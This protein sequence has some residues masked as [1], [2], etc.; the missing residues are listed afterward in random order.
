MK[1]FQEADL[2]KSTTTTFYSGTRKLLGKQS[3]NSIRV[4][5]DLLFA[6]GTSV[7]GTAGKVIGKLKHSFCFYSIVYNDIL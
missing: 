3:I 4:H 2:Q 7:D 6:G 1:T 5:D